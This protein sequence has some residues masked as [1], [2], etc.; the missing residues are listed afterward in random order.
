MSKTLVTAFVAGLTLALAPTAMAQT[1]DLAA[2]AQALAGVSLDQLGLDLR[3]ATELSPAELQARIDAI[4]AAL[5]QP[6]LN[7]EAR[8]QLEGLLAADRAALDQSAAQAAEEA[9]G[10]AEQAAEQPAEQP[11]E[12][13]AEAPAAEE[14]AGAASID[15]PAAEEQPAEATEQ[16]AEPP[17]EAAEEAAEEAVTE[18]Q[19][20]AEEPVTEKA[21]EEP[22]ETPA[23]EAAEAPADQPAA[24]AE[25]TAAEP[26]GATEE[27]AKATAAEEP[28]QE[29]D[30][31]AAK[32][33]AEPAEEQA[34]G[35]AEPAES[36]A[37]AEE[38]KAQP[39]VDEEPQVSEEAE[40]AA[41]KLLADET[42]AADLSDEALRERV[43][44]YRELLSEADL[45]RDTARALRER[46]KADRNVLRERVAAKQSAEAEATALAAAQGDETAQKSAQM[47]AAAKKNDDDDDDD[48]G[49]DAKDLIIPGVLALAALPLVLQP[50]EEEV[51]QIVRDDRPATELSDE[52]LN[53]RIQALQMAPQT[54]GFTQAEL[55]AVEQQLAADRLELRHRLM[56]ARAARAA[57]WQEWEEQQAQ[58]QMNVG[59]PETPAPPELWA[60]EVDDEQIWRQLVAAPRAPIA[61]Q[62]PLEAIYEHPERIV[63]QPRVRAALP[64]IELDT[65]TFGFNEAFIR[66]E[67]IF[68]LDR[69]A[70]MI[71]G[72]I[73]SHPN[74]IF[75]IEG[76]TDAVGSEAYNLRLSRQR[77]EAVKAAITEYYL[78]PP[79]NIV[80]AGLGEQFLKI[81]TPEAEEENRRVTVRRITPLVSGYNYQ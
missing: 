59:L 55:N 56:A 66:E 51:P 35:A 29:A 2:E 34:Q 78:V 62:Y 8:G 79:E 75:L 81:W 19:P 77:A 3:P 31:Q 69:I 70:R 13:Q 46:L 50:H 64:S 74:E 47:Q 17:A 58:I 73:A 37:A 61:R 9:A 26:Q 43:E 14:E 48:D 1:D 20:A 52:E 41:A 49:F 21:A 68:D 30:E 39:S 10:E 80:T 67:E 25:E 38:V 42:P 57:A 22:A 72:V 5:G 44:K 33:D 63:T 45:S 24:A 76:H 4:E 12:A 71:E 27:P 6:D 18:E 23:E 40:A 15:E 60:A 32:Q 65:I 16:A 36:E 28:A 54:Q 53:R 11:A 7:D